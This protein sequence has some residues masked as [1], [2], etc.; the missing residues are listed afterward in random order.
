MNDAD[1]DNRVYLWHIRDA[2]KRIEDYTATGEEQFLKSSMIQNAVVWN[3]GVIGEAVRS[4]SK[5]LKDAHPEIPWVK[6]AAMRHRVIHEYFNI[7]LKLVWD[8]VEKEIP[9][10]KSQVKTILKE[11][12]STG[13]QRGG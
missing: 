7:N 2:I 13:P 9:L 10:L 11:L 8:V 12:E 4:I 5:W 3:I 1:K 6:I